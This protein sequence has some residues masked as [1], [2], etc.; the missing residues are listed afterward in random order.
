MNANAGDQSRD[1][2]LQTLQERFG[3]DEF[4][5]HQREVCD[6]VV[7]GQDCLL[8]MPTG[9]GKS[10]CYQLPGL[11]R[12]RGTLVISPLIALMEDQ[13]AK[14]RANDIEADRIHSGLSRHAQQMTFRRWINR[15]LDFL[16]IA[17]ERLRVP[18]FAER[19]GQDP[20]GLIAVDEAHCISMWGHD[21]RPDYRLLG[22]RLPLLRGDGPDAPPI[23]AMTA[24]ATV[25]VQGDIL[26]QLGMGESNAFIRGFVRHNLAIEI[27]ECTKSERPDR[28]AKL[29]ADDAARPAIVYALSKREVDAIAA[30]LADDHDLRAAAYHAGMATDHRNNVQERFLA[31]ELDVVVAT[32]AFG[33]GVDKADIR[34][35]LHVG[36]PATVEGYY[37]EIGRA[38]RDGQPSRA[39]ALYSWADR[40]LHDFLRDRSYPPLS[41]LDAVLYHIPD[42]PIP[43]DWLMGQVRLEP[44]QA[45][46]A[47]GKLRV[48]GAVETTSHD[49]VVRL[50]DA[51]GQRWRSDYEQQ[52]A[53]RMAQLDDIFRFAATANCRMQELVRYFGEREV[54]RPCGHCDTCAPEACTARQFRSPTEQECHL[55]ESLVEG[56]AGRGWRSAGRVHK[57]AI[58]ERLA[59]RRTFD[60]LLDGV[61][62]A[63]IVHTRTASFD[64][65]GRTITYREICLERGSWPRGGKWLQ[66]VQ[67]DDDAMRPKKS[68]AKKKRA[69]STKKSASS[70]AR[71]APPAEFSGDSALVDEL[72]AWRLARARTEGV[73][74]YVVLTNKALFAVATHLPTTDEELLAIPGIGPAKV[75]RYGADL[76]AELRTR[77]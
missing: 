72:K 35:V 8:V 65:D 24:T 26:R 3:H 67:L 37:Q 38:G 6:A 20:P 5:P 39:I 43:R 61:A 66:S 51:R 32:V 53:W 58:G 74:A 52:L 10:L 16:L 7:A 56:L 41:A 23:V 25:R 49:E 9:G 40:R 63:G 1:V 73:P 13:V 31:G 69:K 14:L 60:G 54:S 28:V 27:V 18:G 48:H 75:A 50:P 57:D 22:E 29:L 62:R 19:L 2:M 46:A 59:D 71:S 44:E 33:M 11:V 47:L 17:P 30:S 21:F 68:K 45:E 42:H 15:E 12:G 4:R 77:G 34:T 55:L 36:L 64:K 70:R 76:L